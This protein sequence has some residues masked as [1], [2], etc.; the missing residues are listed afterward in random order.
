[1]STDDNADGA[2]PSLDLRS[3]L[4]Y[5]FSVLSEVVAQGFARQYLDRF[6][7]AIPEWRVLATLGAHSPLTAKAIGQHSRMHKTKV[8]RAVTSL[9]ARG[10]VRGEVSAHDRREINLWLSDQGRALHDELIPLAHEYE[11]E[12]IRDIPPGDL[13]IMARTMD[14]IFRRADG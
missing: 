10:L 2:H 12:I 8:S 1:M 6:G 11:A 5:R 13:E 4:P 9:E 14:I 3:Y 7:L